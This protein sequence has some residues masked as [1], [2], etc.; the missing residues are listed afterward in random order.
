[1]SLPTKCS[2]GYYA[3]NG[4]DAAKHME[5]HEPFLSE[6]RCHECCVRWNAFCPDGIKVW[7]KVMGHLPLHKIKLTCPQCDKETGYFIADTEETSNG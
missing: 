5:T 3:T 6:A 2:C 4:Y 7:D 1:M